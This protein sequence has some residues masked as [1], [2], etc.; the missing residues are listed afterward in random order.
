MRRDPHHIANDVVLPVFGSVDS[1]DAKHHKNHRPGVDQRTNSW[2]STCVST[3][4]VEAKCFG[5]L[6]F[7]SRREI[8]GNITRKSLNGP[9]FIR[10]EMWQ[11]QRENRTNCLNVNGAFRHQLS[12]HWEVECKMFPAWVHLAQNWCRSQVGGRTRGSGEVSGG[13]GQ[14]TV[15]WKQRAEL[16]SKSTWRSIWL[17][18]ACSPAV[19]LQGW[20]GVK[21]KLCVP[22]VTRLTRGGCDHPAGVRVVSMG[23]THCHSG[24]VIAMGL[25]I[26]LFR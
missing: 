26:S 8:F 15:S 23:N 17:S 1:Q 14:S 18:L 21:G 12:H 22:A 7:G 16:K 9:L 5:W 25:I 4:W 6:C 24:G 10:C 11:M 19:L 20:R 13:A 3:A 2:M